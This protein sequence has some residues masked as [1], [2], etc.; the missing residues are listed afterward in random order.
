MAEL[1]ELLL[2]LLRKISVVPPLWPHK[3]F[4][5]KVNGCEVES[6]IL[7][8]ISPFEAVTKFANR[9]NISKTN[10][11]PDVEMN[12]MIKNADLLNANDEIVVHSTVQFT[13][14]TSAESVDLQYGEL[15]DN[16][17]NRYFGFTSFHTRSCYTRAGKGE[18][19]KQLVSRTGLPDL[20]NKLAK[21]YYHNLSFL[22]L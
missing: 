14:V 11:K 20:L 12:Y 8:A 22:C 13:P 5:Y 4:E 15:I 16:T 3:A 19:E 17:L 21:K 9:M 18:A 1:K 6:F 7:K 10:H 2:N